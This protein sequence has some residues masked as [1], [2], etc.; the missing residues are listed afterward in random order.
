MTQYSGLF[1]HLVHDM[2]LLYF[3]IIMEDP[4]IIKEEA[5]VNSSCFLILPFFF[6]NSLTS[7]LGGAKMWKM[8]RVKEVTSHICILTN[9][10]RCS[11]ELIRFHSSNISCDVTKHGHGV[12]SF[13]L[14]KLY[15]N[16][17]ISVEKMSLDNIYRYGS[18]WDRPGG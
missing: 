1:S 18:F 7:F 9:A 6:S 2:N 8:I 10:L 3:S 4:S 14:T 11:D 16:L 17:K 12:R 5:F 13:T 15:S